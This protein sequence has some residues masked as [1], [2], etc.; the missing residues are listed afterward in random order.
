VI[1]LVVPFSY[2]GTCEDRLPWISPTRS[3]VKQSIHGLTRMK[4]MY[5]IT[6]VAQSHWRRIYVYAC[7]VVPVA[8]SVRWIRR[9]W[10]MRRAWRTND[11]GIRTRTSVS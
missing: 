10:A 8:A 3:S 11:A 7:S 4:D 2:D 5:R 6:N 9:A 1:P